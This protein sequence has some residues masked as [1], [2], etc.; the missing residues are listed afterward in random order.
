MQRI[1]HIPFD[2]Q[3]DALHI[4]SAVRRVFS[5]MVGAS[6]DE[7]GMFDPTTHG[8][9]GGKTEGEAQGRMRAAGLYRL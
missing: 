7:A 9:R 1:R 6:D 8:L 3:V 5:Q 4:H 2:N